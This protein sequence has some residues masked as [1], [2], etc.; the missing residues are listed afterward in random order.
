MA[1]TTT[2]Y[3]FDVPTSSDLVKNGATQIALL[4]QDLDTFLFR[5]FSK[6]VIIN[7][8]FDIWQRGTSFGSLTDSAFFADRWAVDFNGTAA[9]RTVSRQSLMGAVTNSSSQYYTR[10]AQSVAGSGGTYN[11]FHQRIESVATLSGQTVTLSFWA[12][13]DAAR[14]VDLACSQV[15][16]TGGSPSAQVNTTIGTATLTTSW[17][18]YSY[19]FAMPSIVGKT[20]GTTAGTD[21]LELDFKMPVNTAMTLDFADIQLE[22]GSQATPFSRIGGSIQGELSACQRYYWRSDY[23]GVEAGSV[24]GHGFIYTSTAVYPAIQN[25]VVMRTKATSIDF[26]NLR[27]EDTA[28]TTLTLSAAVLNNT[29]ALSTRIQGTVTGGTAGRYCQLQAATGGVGGGYIGI[30]AEL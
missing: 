24:F 30:N 2:N 5:P 8:G 3:G 18:K 21:N 4:G 26:A 23:N 22:A 1:T 27:V 9:T 28:A 7:G 6:N 13:A 15:F 19:T 10:Y 29:N 14:S 11:W 20:M 25:P 12:K 16:G 17:A